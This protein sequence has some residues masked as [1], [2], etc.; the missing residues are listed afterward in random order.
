MRFGMLVEEIFLHMFITLFLQYIQYFCYYKF[1]FL[2]ARCNQTHYWS[3]PMTLTIIS[4]I[5][6]NRAAGIILLVSE[7]FNMCHRR[8]VESL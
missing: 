1:M 2:H 3:R 7:G 5:R 8:R 4:G 6:P